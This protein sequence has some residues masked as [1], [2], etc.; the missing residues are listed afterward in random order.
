MELRPPRFWM[1]LSNRGISDL[2]WLVRQ[3]NEHFGVAEYMN[4]FSPLSLVSGRCEEL[5]SWVLPRE[6]SVVI[7]QCTEL[8]LEQI[9]VAIALLVRH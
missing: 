5:L 8:L 2:K 4:Y 6:R 7:I 1:I 3:L 9:L